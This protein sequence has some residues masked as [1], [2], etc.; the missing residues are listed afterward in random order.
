MNTDTKTA[1][2]FG[3]TGFVGRYVV[4]ELAR[5]GYTVKVAG[6]VPERGY[7]LKPYGKVGQ[8]VPVQC[9]YA[10]QQ[11]IDRAVRGSDVV[12]NCIGALYERRRLDFQFLHTDL[13]QAIAGACERFGVKRFVHIS[14]LGVD[15]STSRYAKTKLAGEHAVLDTFPAATIIRPSVIFGPEDEFFNMFAG[16]ARF[17]P[18]LPLIGGGKTKFQPVYVGDVA[19]AIMAAVTR[20]AQGLDN[21]QGAV[22]ELG[23]P[24]VLSF[25]E[26]Y[27]RLF[28]W[29][30]RHRALV[31]L[32]FGIAR[33]QAGF[34]Q[35]IPPKPLLTPDQVLSLQTDNVVSA[36]AMGFA[37]LGLQPTGMALIVPGYLERFRS[38]GRFF[39][40]KSA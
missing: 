30:G 24:E 11:S 13:P 12:V 27:E 1:T 22:F 14:A 32:P 39:D 6:R 5:A 17:M 35:W 40:R 9:V 34:L 7:F 25:K 23:G 4:R 28:Q 2:V 8:I 16:L 38:G 3:G 21:P 15:R 33:I 36:G 31:S 26:I 29:T 20:P 37:E 19:A 18:M 10:D